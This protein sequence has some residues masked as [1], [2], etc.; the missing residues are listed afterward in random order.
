M[1][2]LGVLTDWRKLLIYTH[3]WLGVA[4]CLVFVV[5]FVSGVAMMYWRMPRLTAE[6]RL[7]R[8][9]ALDLSALTVSAADAAANGGISPTRVRVAML[10]GRPVYRFLADGKWS[11]VWADNGTP[12]G[13]VNAD[14]AMATMEALVPEH[15][16]GL[17]YEERLVAPDQ[18]TLQ[19]VI[20][21]HLP[22]HK[23]AVGDEA[24]THYYVSSHTGEPVLKTDRYGR[25]WGYWSAVLHW[26]Y[27]PVLRSRTEF[28]NQL[29]IWAS[30]IGSLMCLGGLALGV[31]RLSLRRRY[32]LKGIPSHSPYAGFMKWHHYAG[33]LFGAVTLT[34]AF[35]GMLSLGP[36]DF[37]GN[38]PAPRSLE[39]AA[40]GGPLSLAALVPDALREAREVIGEAFVPKELEF[41]QFRGH[42]YVMAYRPPEPREAHTW[43]NTD[44][45]AFQALEIDREH[46]IVSVLEPE[47]GVF[48]RFPDAA[49][50]DVAHAA[51]P[52]VAIA[53]ATWLDAYDAYYYD[54]DGH[55]PLP[56]LRVRYADPERTWLYLNPHHGTIAA[57]NEA[58]SRWNRW[59]YQGL[60]SLDFPF[61]YYSRPLW[62]IVVI[63][64]S[65]GG[66]LVSAT[67][68]IPAVRRLR[69]RVRY[70][71]RRLRA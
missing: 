58:G 54:R 7:M 49:M 6:E 4:G 71:G 28:W 48:R 63:G 66:A 61:M 56:V 65:V 8:M 1:T 35:S 59:L 64:L 9:E 10:D 14:E 57:R 44:I 52:G 27:F 23:I 13:A 24:G 3:R 21:D 46:A 22:L 29:I 47:R 70:L 30:G 67:T 55:K 20:R 25:F 26:T 16:A 18:W 11:A 17:R 15:A 19:S 60:H 5:W 33:L 36:W 32:R 12:L 45:A 43:T 53:D 40:T 42:S 37:L 41:L 69:R 51:L 50:S 31:W 2:V 39:E 68:I 38:S 62:D 34:W